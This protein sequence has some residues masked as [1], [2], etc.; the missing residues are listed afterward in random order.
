LRNATTLIIR[1]FIS[2]IDVGV[3]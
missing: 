2:P 3:L 1:F